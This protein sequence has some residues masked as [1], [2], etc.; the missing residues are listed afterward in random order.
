M[1]LQNLV[2]ELRDNILYDRGLS[3]GADDKLWSDATLVRYI[4]E[5]QRRFARRSFVIR[6]ATT[7]EVC[8]LTLVE[9]Q[10]S[11]VLHPAVLAVLSARLE[12][13]N[14]DLA[15]FGHS[16]FAT[17]TS[18]TP[19]LWDPGVV[20]AP[21]GRTAAF[22]TDEQLSEDD[23]G[24]MSTVTMR[25]YPTPRAADDGVIIKLRVI[26]MPLDDLTVNSMAAIPE[27]PIDHHIDMLDWAAYLALRIMD[28]DAGNIARAEKFAASFEAHVNAAR[29]LILKKLFAPQQWGFGRGGWSWGNANGW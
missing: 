18:P 27:I 25:V 28:T 10:T 24:T 15:R 21:T 22:S 12:D 8:N 3:T 26:R 19:M 2:D 13:T 20:T 9:G 14:V 17:N 1:N 29:N 23:D 5:A 7:S 16:D 6:D 4:N 11:Y